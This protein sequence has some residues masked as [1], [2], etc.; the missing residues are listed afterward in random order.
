MRRF[1]SFRLDTANQRLWNREARVAL[2][3]KMFGVL[4]YLVEHP[5]RL[6]TQDELLEAL[7]PD[8]YV[9]PQILRKYIQ[10][11]RKALGTGS[12]SLGLLKLCPNGATSLLLRSLTK[13]LP[14][15]C[16]RTMENQRS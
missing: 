10:E 12:T 5:G 13:T 7:W 6:V 16:R 3:P 4:S 2:A 15:L 1:E 14:G 8:T 9:T 11:I